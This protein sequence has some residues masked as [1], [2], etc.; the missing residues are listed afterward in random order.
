MNNHFLYTLILSLLLFSAC[1]ISNQAKQKTIV[2]ELEKTPCSGKCH[3]YKIQIENN[4]NVFLDGRENINK[5]GN[6]KSTL[7]KKELDE[8]ILSFETINFFELE[9]SYRSFMMDLQ[10]KY[11]SYT[12]DGQTKKIKA[13]DDYP[14]KLDSLIKKIDSLVS[15]QKWIKME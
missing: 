13:Y 8:I 10:T 9:N 12:K 7:S 11:I 2:I 3:V 1:A 6:Y 4:G 14:E 5:I 15:S